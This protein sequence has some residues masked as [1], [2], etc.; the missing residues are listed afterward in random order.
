MAQS[1][2]EEGAGRSALPARLLRGYALGRHSHPAGPPAQPRLTPPHSTRPARPAGRI[3]FSAPT[4]MKLF[5][6]VQSTPVAFPEGVPAT[7]ALRALLLAMLAKA[8]RGRQQR[9][10][11]GAAGRRE[12]GWLQWPVS[13]GVSMS[14]GPGAP[15]L[16]LF[17]ES[18]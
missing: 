4:V 13:C 7:A 12:G 15:A 1:G 9:F 6:V 8:S 2:K 5:E 16:N 17:S 14:L 10:T 3:P 18:R 11:P